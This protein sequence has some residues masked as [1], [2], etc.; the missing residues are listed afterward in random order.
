MRREESKQLPGRGCDR[1]GSQ[2]IHTSFG[3]ILLREPANEPANMHPDFLLEKVG[4]YVCPV[5]PSPKSTTDF[6]RVVLIGNLGK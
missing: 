1:R 5:E 2:Q 4:G 6:L 3:A